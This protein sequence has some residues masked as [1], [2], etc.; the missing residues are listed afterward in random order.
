MAQFVPLQEEFDELNTN[1]VAIS[2]GIEYW[3]RAWLDETQSPFPIWLDAE[4]ASY[5]AYGLGKSWINAWGLR[6]LHYYAQAI[7]GGKKVHTEHRGDTDQMGGNFI[8]DSSGIIRFVY[9]SRD[10][11]DRPTMEVM[12]DVIRKIELDS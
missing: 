5:N 10:P 4:R 12:M 3:A 8:V 9:P 1:I 7:L 2:F 11:T 6:N